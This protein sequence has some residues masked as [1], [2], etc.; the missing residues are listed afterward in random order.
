[1]KYF[2]VLGIEYK[3]FKK[4]ANITIHIGDR[5]IDTFQLTRDY[6]RTTNILPQI[7]SKWLERYGRGHYLTRA[8]WVERWAR[9]RRFQVPSL[10]KVYEVDDS[11]LK[12][13][14]EI[15]V[16]N[17]N[18][19]FT[20]G[21]MKHSSLIKFPMVALFKKDLVGNRGEKMMKAIVKFD[22]TLE[23]YYKRK[24]QDQNNY[25]VSPHPGYVRPSW[26]NAHSFWV[27]RENGVKD[28]RDNIGGSFTAEFR[29]KTK[30]HMKV[31]APAGYTKLVGFPSRHGTDLILA[32]Y[33]PLLNIYDEDKR[34]NR[35][36]D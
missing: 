33:K 25:W 28:E 1:M 35:T 14:M 34:S 20:N 13:R 8:D 22:D 23:K 11:A 31:F 12:D 10:I 29:I 3:F 2:I 6:P 17:A 21:F 9:A 7:E 4:P 24:R 16:E 5:L 18:S 36:K 32:S 30:H 26:P 19:N 27:S 15:E